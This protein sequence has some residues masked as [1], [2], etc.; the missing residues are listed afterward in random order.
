MS[1]FYLKKSDTL[2]TISATLDSLYGDN[3]TLLGATVHF[4]MR[5]RGS[6]INT[7][8]AV[9]AIVDVD[10]RTVIY[11]WQ[12]GD[13]VSVGTYDAEFVVT[14]ADNTVRSF[15]NYEFLTIAIVGNLS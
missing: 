8:D 11:T 10:A 9:A 4:K 12:S 7:V 3:H 6:T 14:Y 15:P 5:K 2:P 13:T 1:I